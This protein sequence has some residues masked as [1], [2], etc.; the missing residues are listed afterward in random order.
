M[1]FE[2]RVER[3]I[4]ASPADVFEAYTSVEAQRVRLA[5]G[6][7][8]EQLYVEVSGDPVQGGPWSTAWGATADEL[9]HEY[10]VYSVFERPHRI[11]T[12]ATFRTPDGR[13]ME[14]ELELTFEDLSG[15]TRLTIVQRGIPTEQVRD[16]VTSV[17]WPGVLDNLEHYLNSAA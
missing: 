11:V 13:S 9:F 14:S 17:A 3:V 16:F 5:R 1:T 12:P 4:N 6:E 10:G 2:T 7:N 15:Q 8:G